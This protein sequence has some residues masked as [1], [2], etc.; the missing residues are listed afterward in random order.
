[1]REMQHDFNAHNFYM[2][3]DNTSYLMFIACQKYV[4]S[5]NTKKKRAYMLVHFDFGGSMAI[6]YVYIKRV[7]FMGYFFYAWLASNE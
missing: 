7:L 4:L 5:M 6:L 2:C 1:M 3:P